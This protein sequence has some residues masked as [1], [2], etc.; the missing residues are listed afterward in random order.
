MNKENSE[1]KIFV[2]RC[3]TLRS[4]IDILDNF[5]QSPRVWIAVMIEKIKNIS[6]QEEDYISSINQVCEV[7]K[8]EN[9]E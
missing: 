5:E 9:Y 7:L 6:S 1:K 2:E 3:I 4:M 8:M